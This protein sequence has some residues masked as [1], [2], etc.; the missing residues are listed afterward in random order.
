MK[1]I[2][3]VFCLALALG[4]FSQNS[5]QPSFGFNI[6]NINLGGLG[7]SSLTFFE[8]GADYEH[9][10]TNQFGINGGASYNFGSDLSNGGGFFKINV[11]GRYNINEL[12]DGLFFGGD[13]DFGFRENSNIMAFRANIGYSIPIGQGS[14]NPNISAGY[15]SSGSSGFRAGGFYL[16]INVSYSINL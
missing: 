7:S 15:M 8:L 1:Q 4:S 9:G 12:N 3:T 5:I 14:L 13:L 16:P 2:F 6:W 10:L 11:G